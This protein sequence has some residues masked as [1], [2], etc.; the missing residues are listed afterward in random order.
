MTFQW[1]VATHRGRVRQ[2]NEDSVHPTSSGRGEDVLV[3]VADGMGG[4]VAGE[5]ASRLAVEAAVEGSGSEEE[6][7]TAGNAAILET[8]SARPEL[9][10][11]GSTVTLV[12]LEGQT[13]R[14]AHVGDSRAYLLRDG[15]FTQVTEDHTV[16]NDYLRAGAIS[17]EEVDSHPQRHMLTRAVGL[18]P[19]L[20]VDSFTRR[21]EPGDRLLVCSDGLTGML[22]D[23]DIA[24]VLDDAT[25]EEAVWEL[26]E[27]ANA[28]GGQ[29]NITVVVVD[30]EP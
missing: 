10:G 27:R 7:V 22:S 4:A 23:D 6:L 25:P 14:F 11:M 16:V 1:A 3:V 29:D 26:V 24:G 15:A 20:A 13:A 21:L 2:N 18:D 28:A 19:D 5:V 17:A 8:V 12:R 9:A 30:V